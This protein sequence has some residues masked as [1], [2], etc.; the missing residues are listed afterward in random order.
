MLVVAFGVT[1][2]LSTDDRRSR[3]IVPTGVA[4]GLA[5]LAS[6]SALPPLIAVFAVVLWQRRGE[7]RFIAASAGA[8]LIAGALLAPWTLR[9]S[10]RLGKPIWSRS[11]FGLELAMAHNA[12]AAADLQTNLRNGT[13]ARH[14]FVT[15]EER[16]LVIRMGEVR[17][18]EARL[19]EAVEWIRANPSRAAWL[20]AQRVVLFWFP[21]MIRWPQTILLAL[22]TIGAAFGVAL[23]VRHYRAPATLAGAVLLAYPLVYYAVQAF[24]RYRYGIE[25]LLWL[26]TGLSMTNW[27]ARR[28]HVV[29]S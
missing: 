11:N 10:V 29:E 5:L 27:W 4:W 1:S 19:S 12:G 17:Y 21:R 24:P 9:N 25:W 3:R 16:A 6:P 23:M 14:P 8:V 18:N 13:Y 28:K 22:L 2:R 20:T 15:A 7:K 26:M